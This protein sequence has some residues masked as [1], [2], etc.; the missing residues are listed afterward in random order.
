[1]NN[2][3]HLAQ[4]RNRY[5]LMR[6]GKSKANAE[7]LIVSHPEHGTI[8][9]GLV[10]EGIKQATESV[11]AL[12][13]QG[14]L[15]ATTIIITS[16]FLR[17]RETAEIARALLGV[18]EVTVSELL[19][20]RNFGDYELQ[21]TEHFQEIWGAEDV[22]DPTFTSHK[23]ESPASVHDRTTQL[24]RELEETYEGKKI[25][26]VSHGDTTQILQTAFE[27]ISPAEHLSIPHMQ[28]GEIRE[29]ELVMK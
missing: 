10:E 1:M 7:K 9:Y 22:T 8:G 13:D 17:T 24:I 27:G 23:V 12:R 4:L 29:V 15:D 21:S 3:T 20:E 2:L 19:R 6:H 25:L 14:I 11:T 28:T 16:D 26:L 18:E 5:F